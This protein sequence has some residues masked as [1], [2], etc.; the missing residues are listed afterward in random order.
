M[1]ISIRSAKA[2][3]REHHRHNPSVAGART[4]IGLELDGRL[5]GVGL[6][7]NPKA[8]ELAADRTC[9]EAVR[10]CVSHE[11]PKGASSKINSRL[12][13]IW[14]LHG[15][16][17]FITYNRADE[18]GAS[19]RGAGLTPTSVVKGRQWNCQSRPRTVVQDVVDKVRWEQA[20]SE[21]PA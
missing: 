4:A 18:S 14:Q 8:R 6:L 16:R 20:L 15:G 5:V 2:F 13:R 3:V 1:P 17:R 9:A 21:V 7:G 19:M 11:A 12:K 10:V